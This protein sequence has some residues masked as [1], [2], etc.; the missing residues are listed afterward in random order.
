MGQL[1]QTVSITTGSYRS[2][3]PVGSGIHARRAA[4]TATWKQGIPPMLDPQVTLRIIRTDPSPKRN[5]QTTYNRVIRFGRNLR[6]ECAAGAAGR[7]IKR[8][9]LNFPH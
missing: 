5:S 2:F 6:P 3:Y 7:V 1:L 4:T 8:K 9:G